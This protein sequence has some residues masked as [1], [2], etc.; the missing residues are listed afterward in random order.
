MRDLL[1]LLLIPFVLFA[2]VAL[3]LTAHT[4]CFCIG[5]DAR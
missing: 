4:V 1:A 5:E 3:Y 2:Y